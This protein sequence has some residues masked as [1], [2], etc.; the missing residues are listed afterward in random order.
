MSVPSIVIFIPPAV[1]A[2][3]LSRSCWA[4]DR[5]APFSSADVA[6]LAQRPAYM[7]A[8]WGD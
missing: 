7:M 8:G 3:K 2:V 4:A 1:T 5:T 6:V